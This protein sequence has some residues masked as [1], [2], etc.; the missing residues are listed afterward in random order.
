VF[1]VYFDM[2]MGGSAV[3]IQW[4]RIRIN[5]IQYK[6]LVYFT[7]VLF[8]LL[9]LWVTSGLLQMLMQIDFRCSF[10]LQVVSNLLV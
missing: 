8:F 6:K 5:Y 2:T 1:T 4:I 7:F 9:N 3:S 10:A